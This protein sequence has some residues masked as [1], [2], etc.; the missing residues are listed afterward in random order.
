MNCCFRIYLN[1]NTKSTVWILHPGI[2]C[3]KH[4]IE[5]LE[6]V[7]RRTVKRC[8]DVTVL[9]SELRREMEDGTSFLS[10]CGIWQPWREGAEEP[11]LRFIRWSP[12]KR[13][14][15]RVLELTPSKT[16]R[17]H[18]YKL[19]K[20]AKA[21]LEQKLFSVRIINTWNVVEDSIVSMNTITASRWENVVE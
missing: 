14:C 13:Q 18:T 17:S 8:G 11:W 12:E 16:A 21:P 3:L 6:K 19:F 9:K 5:Q 7:E 10:A 2:P 20:K 15:E 1:L 4:G